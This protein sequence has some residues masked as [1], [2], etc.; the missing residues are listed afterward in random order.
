[1]AASVCRAGTATRAAHQAVR[2][3]EHAAG[4]CVDRARSSDVAPRV[5]FDGRSDQLDQRVEVRQRAATRATGTAILQPGSRRQTRCRN[6]GLLSQSVDHRATLAD[7]GLNGSNLIE[8]RGT[9]R[10]MRLRLGDLQRRGKLTRLQTR[11]ENVCLTRSSATG[12]GE[13]DHE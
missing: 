12:G 11:L 6:T 13:R 1:M 8:L 9:V 3:D 2:I 10:V 7:R 4:K 5:G